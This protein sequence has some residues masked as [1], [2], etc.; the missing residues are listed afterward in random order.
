MSEKG[1]HR[2]VLLGFLVGVLCVLAILLLRWHDICE[3]IVQEGLG[4]EF[5]QET[6]SKVLE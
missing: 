4:P 6:V 2:G 1:F 3:L 5:F